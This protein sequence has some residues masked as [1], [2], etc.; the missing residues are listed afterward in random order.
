MGG[1]R[2]CPDRAVLQRLLDGGLD[3]R[4][5]RVIEGHL[6]TCETCQRTLDALACGDL[7][8]SGRI[9][10]L[11]QDPAPAAPG[12]KRAIGTLKDELEPGDETV[13]HESTTAD[14]VL[15]LLDPPEAPGDLGK[16]GPY[17]V[18]QLLGQGGMGIVFRAFDS[19]LHRTV[20]IKILA[21]QLAT[22]SSARQRF[23]REARAAAAVRNEHVVAIHAVDE[24]RG[25]PFLVM[26]FIPGVS[27]QERIDRS[28]PLDVDS[29]LRIGAQAASGLAAAH[30]QGLV[31][32]D[33]KPSN[34]LLENGVERV[35]LTDY[36]LARAVDDAS[37][38]HSGVVAGTPLFMAPEQARCETIDHR[39]DLFSL[40]SVLYAMAAG[41]SPFRA[42]TTMGVL[43]R[44]CDDAHR[45]LRAI[46]PDVPKELAAVIDRLLDKEP[47]RRYGSAAEVAETL[48]RL[49]A[50]RQQGKEPTIEPRSV[51]WRRAFTTS[52][53]VGPSKHRKFRLAMPLGLV[54]LILFTFAGLLILR[55]VVARLRPE[56]ST[57]VV[58]NS[59]PDIK[60][61]IDEKFPLLGTGRF[62][63]VFRPPVSGCVVETFRGQRRL[64]QMYLSLRPGLTIELDVDEEGRIWDVYEGPMRAPRLWKPTTEAKIA[65]EPGEPGAT[66]TELPGP[67]STARLSSLPLH[68]FMKSAGG[69]LAMLHGHY[70]VA[71][72][73]DGN[74]EVL[75][76]TSGQKWA[77]K[78]SN[79]R[80]TSMAAIPY[81]YIAVGDVDQRVSRW[82]MNSLGSF[83]QSPIPDLRFGPHAGAVVSLAARSD[84]Y[85]LA[86]AGSKNRVE[87]WDLR[88]GRRLGELGDRRPHP[89]TSVRFAPDDG[90]LAVGLLGGGVEFWRVS[91]VQS[92]GGDQELR[93]ASRKFDGAPLRVVALEFSGDGRFLAAAGETQVVVW[94]RRLGASSK[95]P[96]LDAPKRGKLTALAG[97]PEGGNLFALGFGDGSVSIC[98]DGCERARIRAYDAPIADLLFPPDGTSL[99][100]SAWQAD[101]VRV[102]DLSPMVTSFP[103]GV[104][105]T[106][107]QPESART[108][109]EKKARISQARTQEELAN[110]EVKKA[111][112]QVESAKA[113][114]QSRRAMHMR[115]KDLAGR[116][117]IESRL[118]EEDQA[119]LDAAEAD[120]R[121][122]QYGLWVAQYRQLQSELAI[123]TAT[124]DL[125][126]PR[127]MD[128]ALEASA[129][130]ARDRARAEERAMVDR[131]VARSE[132]E[133][134][135]ASMES[136]NAIRVYRRKV[137]D[138]I[139]EQAERNAIERRVVEE[140]EHQARVAESAVHT[141]EAEISRAETLLKGAEEELSAR[142]EDALSQDPTVALLKEGIRVARAQI[143]HIKK[144]AR[145]E[146]RDP[147]FISFRNR[148]K[149]LQDRYEG[150]VK[151]ESEEISRRLDRYRPGTARPTVPD[152]QPTETQLKSS[153]AIAEVNT[154]LSKARASRELANAE[155]KRA[156]AQLESASAH[157]DY[158]K[159]SH[160]RLME[161]A[162]QKAIEA[163]LVDEA[164]D[165]RL[166]AESE[167]DSARF[168]LKAAQL[169]Q[170]LADIGIG[171]AQ[172][173]LDQARA[174]AGAPEAAERVKKAGVLLAEFAMDR[175]RVERDMALDQL[176]QMKARL[177]G[178]KS[179]LSYRQ[180]LFER[181]RQ[182]A[183]RNEIEQRLVDEAEVN[184][185]KSRAGVSDAEAEVSR[186]EVLLKSAEEK[187]RR[188]PQAGAK[189][190]APPVQATVEDDSL[191]TV[192]DALESIKVD[193]QLLHDPEIVAL[194]GEIQATSEEL[195]YAL[196]ENRQGNDPA[197]I[198]ALRHRKNLQDE[199]QRLLREKREQIRRRSRQAK[200]A[201]D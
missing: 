52:E 91:V 103:P 5:Q 186:A 98:L 166:V 121:A 147:A 196:S 79:V 189:V 65:R 94:D 1:H 102:W 140:S 92:P 133:R 137:V 96:D 21:P 179:Q 61:V 108:I 170:K 70:L 187:L 158:I 124:A 9:R 24:W 77:H 163:R 47:S 62:D 22:V 82:D 64:A 144:V 15:N 78:I 41:R 93:T 148:L 58:Y 188:Q 135:K 36:G 48:N 72:R 156:E 117:A 174:F 185:L 44:V 181:L 161:L 143:E 71:C 128:G 180:K 123:D 80:V 89:V 26:E 164:E 112:A 50:A 73:Q 53:D 18:V 132:L 173:E 81:R 152:D 150:R 162:R 190:P 199:R 49:L 45:P 168:E 127:E 141:A 32:R 39:A 10:D 20:A 109:E 12:L 142:I 113:H 110:A 86:T 114:A 116:K 90:T 138:R 105:V 3:V 101:G 183:A 19:T 59:E 42:T 157:A 69:F 100:T 175:A 74:V 201:R 43:R 35:K 129:Q 195:L 33:I 13:A 134:A 115:L 37:L 68:S 139:R 2:S 95:L 54:L 198:A 171:E 57:L 30:A 191:G 14:E 83:Q 84:G 182:L 160:L 167:L 125:K 11:A 178:A 46:N 154:R 75:D 56:P 107:N 197:L 169:R 51:F 8:W 88:D 38:T 106:E 151:A 118:V 184:L 85:L 40:G 67:P 159:S 63:H 76:T 16:L 6:E 153:K 193:E 146:E 126:R 4:E 23:A 25:L 119:Q 97:S 31:H 28:A 194:D 87:I 155:V 34:I 200:T 66:P 145:N 99:V 172:A 131:D 136:A 27:L 104:E 111:E 165:K 60:V 176:A 149:E 17:R 177:K 55:Q 29:I 122:A 7:E 192:Q 130:Q 120:L